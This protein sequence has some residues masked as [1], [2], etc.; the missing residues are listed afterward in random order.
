MTGFP[1]VPVAPDLLGRH[2]DGKLQPATDLSGIAGGPASDGRRLCVV[3]DDESQSVQIAIL[4]PDGLRAGAV[5]RLSD[6]RFEGKPLELDAEA[7]A[8][9]DGAFY[10]CGSHGRPRHPKG[11][12]DARN[13]ARAEASRAVFRIALSP[14]MVDMQSGALL[15]RPEITRSC[16][17]AGLIR[18]EPKLAPAF[19]LPLDDN[20]LTIEGMAVRGDTAFFGFRAPVLADGA[21]I[22]AVPLARLFGVATEDRPALHTLDLG[23]DTAG[24]PRG[25][26]DLTFADGLFFGIAGPVDDPADDRQPIP[27]ADYALFR[28][29]GTGR[30]ALCE[31]PGFAA[32]TKPEALLPLRY[33]ADALTAILFFDG[34][35][36]GAPV[37]IQ[38]G[39]GAPG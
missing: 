32:K 33:E 34:P 4:T 21:A 10:V 6:A 17:L 28:W 15:S 37:L 30:P 11:H 18:A 16:A 12:S 14:G 36:N 5:I 26:R 39:F 2:R 3:A 23:G 35:P 25:I 38:Q 29:D 22:M 13:A 1:R 19:D 31:L 7:V 27:A 8:W 20:G 9:A 24:K